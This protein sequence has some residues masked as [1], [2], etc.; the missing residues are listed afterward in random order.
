MIDALYFDGRSARAQPVRLRIEGDELVADGEAARRWPLA[1]VRWPERTRHGQRVIHLR[2]GGSLQMLD[3]AAFDTWRRGTDGRESWVV[4]AQQNWRATLAA[5]LALLLVVTAGYL[6][7]VPLA[8]RVLVAALPQSIDAEVGDAALAQ[9]D[10]HWLQPSALPQARR[11]A[12]RLAFAAAVARAYPDGRAPRW[13]LHFRAADKAVGAN[14]FALPGGAIVITDALVERLQGADDTIVG[15]LAHELGHLRHRHGLRAV[16]QLSL[17][18]S[19]AG[20]AFGDFSSLLAGAPALLGQMGYSRDAER[21]ADAEAARVL[22][23]SGRSPAA[24][25]VLF[26]RLRPQPGAGSAL[27]IAF[28]SHPMDD[29]RRAFFRAAAD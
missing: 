15:V 10:E 8:A 18:G 23:A 1:Q 11:D 24:M 13:V 27:A 4:R 29:E 2:D 25:L 7:G 6:W 12:V 14:A 19:A 21:E 26:D 17:V 3:A 9:I 28:A 22:K 20:I 16:V 5:T